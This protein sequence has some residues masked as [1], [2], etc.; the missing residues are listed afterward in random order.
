[1][2]NKTLV[3]EFIGFIDDY[4]IS[5]VDAFIKQV[6]SDLE[7]LPINNK[8]FDVICSNALEPVNLDN[9]QAQFLKVYSNNFPE[10]FGEWNEYHRSQEYKS[11]SLKTKIVNKV[12]KEFPAQGTKDEVKRIL[13]QHKL[14][15]NLDLSL[16]IIKQG[17][18]NKSIQA[19][20]EQKTNWL[21]QLN[22]INE[23]YNYS[24]WLDWASSNAKNVN[25]ATHIAKLTHSGI[26]GASNIFFNK[27][28]DKNYLSTASLKNRKVEVSQND[29]R[30]SPIGKLLQLRSN[31]ES[32]SDLLKNGN[33]AIFEQFAKDEEQLSKWRKGFSSVFSEKDIATTHYLAK[34]IYFPINHNN[35]CDAK[36]YHLVSPMMSSSLDQEIFEKVNFAKY[37]KEMVEI[38][39]Q[40]RGEVYHQDIQVSYP[41]LAILKVTASNHGNAGSPLNGKRSG[42]RYLLPSTP[43]TWKVIQQPPLN[44]KTMYAGEFDKRAWKTVKELQKYL[45]KLN[46]KEF[47]NKPIRDQVKQHINDVINILFD[48]VLYIQAMPAGWS[49]KS[50]LIEAHA[51][52]LDINRDDKKFQEKRK[53]G[54]WQDDICQDFGLW[55]NSKL[56]NKKMKLVKFE[57]DKWAKLLKNRLNLFDKGLEKSQ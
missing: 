15:Y 13:D 2:K 29:N 23:K 55:M 20:E 48:Y 44:Q 11:Q 19:I 37:S 16:E 28:D 41:R 5:K 3:D 35:H 32:L 42:K 52:W 38:R 27:T 30:F 57:K 1:M 43:P 50:K 33:L 7:K 54:Q 46:T 24:N 18:D 40:K 14:A 39:K 34:Q 51:L 26:S 36:N 25:F 10:A 31:N 12:K 45:I 4:K 53:S 6:K 56:S 17:L 8:E 21:R 9:V 49:E 47:G 22:D